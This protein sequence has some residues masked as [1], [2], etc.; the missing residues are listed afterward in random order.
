MAEKIKAP[1]VYQFRP[2]KTL[3]GVTLFFLALKILSTGGLVACQVYKGLTVG[4][5]D[6][7]DLHDP[8]VAVYDLLCL[9]YLTV[10]VISGIVTLFWM[11]GATRNTLAIRPELKM[12]Q[13]GAVGWW[14]VPFASLYKPYQYVRDIWATAQ[15]LS[16]RGASAAERPLAIW[17][18]SFLGGNVISYIVSK[19]AP[20]SWIG[21]SIGFALI[22]ISS[23][24]FFAIVRTVGRNQKA[25][26]TAVA[27]VF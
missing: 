2:L 22:L 19:A 27:E 16:G 20:D 6:V 26:S 21:T 5:L 23:V 13:L 24:L 12:S 1:K 3:T 25:Q 10:A 4:R 8:V 14:F 17:W 15:G 9:G 11:A 18:F 7:D